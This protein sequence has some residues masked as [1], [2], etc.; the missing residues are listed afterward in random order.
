[1]AT[2]QKELGDILRKMES[3]PEVETENVDTEQAP[4]ESEDEVLDT[5]TES[6]TET[7]ETVEESQE[8]E[9]TMPEDDEESESVSI[10]DLNELATAIEVEPEFLY[11]IKVPMADGME[12]ISLSELK[13]GYTQFKRGTTADLEALEEER[14]KFAEFREEQLNA[15]KQQAQLPQEIMA[16]Q[17]K[18][19]AIAQQ[20]NSVN[21]D[22]LEKQDPGKAAL[23][24]QKMATA[25]QTATGEYQQALGKFQE[26]QT[27]EYQENL[28]QENAKL[29]KVIPEWN[30]GSVRTREQEE[31]RTFLKNYGY[32]DNEISGI[33]D[34]R[35]LKLARDLWR[36]KS[37][38]TTAQ[39]KLKKIAKI[40]KRV[41]AGTVTKAERQKQIKQSQ[42]DGAA[43]SKNLDV[44]VQTISDL[45]STRG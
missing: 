25:Y 36:L 19:I 42:I 31:M 12:P 8:A 18:A 9:A 10:A 6:R 13:D 39:Q 16:A 22:E 7:E 38:Q 44:K 14:A 35:A 43:K 40:P 27:Q 37:Q 29:V 17:A 15:I 32:T 1:M 41:K 20:Y 3:K 11:N 30:D 34:H 26:Q 5:E 23:E 2:N 33:A 21:W 24:Q 28:T 4:T 45:I